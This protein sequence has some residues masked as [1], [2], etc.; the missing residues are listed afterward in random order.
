M[1]VKHF[2]ETRRSLATRLQNVQ[3][4]F[5][6]T[7]QGMHAKLVDEKNK[8]AQLQDSMYASQPVPATSHQFTN[9]SQEALMGGD[10]FKADVDQ[11]ERQAN[12][13]E[14]LI[15][16]QKRIQEQQSQ[17]TE[18]SLKSVENTRGEEAASAFAAYVDP[19]DIRRNFEKLREAVDSLNSSQITMKLQT[20]SV[21]QHEQSK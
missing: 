4:P 2:R 20:D 7:V 11:M 17:S 3:L 21:M 14:K 13:I 12:R 15:S 5:E 16:I 18:G 6:K 19:V 10:S 8:I 1:F 9:Q